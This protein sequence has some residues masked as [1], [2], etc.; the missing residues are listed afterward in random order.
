MM[1]VPEGSTY[2]WLRNQL[3]AGCKA[4]AGEARESID[5]AAEMRSGVAFIMEL[6]MAML[7]G[8]SG[9]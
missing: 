6:P 5:R 9:I 2:P 1:R 4:S 3:S 7:A 8:C